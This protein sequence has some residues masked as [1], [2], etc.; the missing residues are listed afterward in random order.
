MTGLGFKNSLLIKLAEIGTGF[1]PD[2]KMTDIVNTANINIIDKK[3]QEFQL[4][5][6]ITRELEPLIAT[7]VTLTPVSS[8]IDISHTSVQVPN[9]YAFGRMKVSSPFLGQNISKYAKERKMMQNNVYS[10][11]TARYPKYYITAGIINIEP[12]N[13]ISCVV[14]YFTTPFVIDITN[15]IIDIPYN[16]K[17]IQLLFSECMIMFG[18]DSRDMTSIQLGTQQEV[19]NK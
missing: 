10:Q 7:T 18:V 16:Q 3:I 13:V 5:S 11:G 15:N 19:S 4:N 6:K 8:T 2:V 12:A 14:T 17:L 9:Y 1:I